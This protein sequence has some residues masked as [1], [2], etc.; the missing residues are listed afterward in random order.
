MWGT[1]GCRV[2]NTKEA[3]LLIF[4]IFSEFYLNVMWKTK[5]VKIFR[6][7]FNLC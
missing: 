2:L 6:V 3:R 5:S 1:L 7:S 4:R